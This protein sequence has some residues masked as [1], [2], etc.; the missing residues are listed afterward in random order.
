LAGI[1][2]V[3]D[4]TLPGRGIIPSIPSVNTKKII[5]CITQLKEN[6]EGAFRR[7][8]ECDFFAEIRI[9]SVVP[10]YR[11]Q[12]LGTEIYARL[13]QFL[14]AKGFP[15]LRSV[16][17]SGAT[18]AIGAKFGFVEI[19]RLYFRDVLDENGEK[20]FPTAGDGKEECASYIACRL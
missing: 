14:R 12:G 3:L 11:N 6:N 13:M 10:K 2:L 4:S 18:W 8:F 1:Q 16:F 15:V 20:L 17:T 9:S 19:G 7:D 5:G